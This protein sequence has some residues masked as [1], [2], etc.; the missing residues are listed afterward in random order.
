MPDI[1]R[2]P[3]EASKGL[4]KAAGIKGITVTQVGDTIQI[5]LP[6]IASNDDPRLELVKELFMRTPTFYSNRNVISLTLREDGM[7]ISGRNSLPEFGRVLSQ[8]NE[9]AQSADQRQH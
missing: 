8:H 4:T 1:I 3:S 9:A 7:H 6:N 2:T 5:F